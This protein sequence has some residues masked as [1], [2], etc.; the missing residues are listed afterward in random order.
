MP[1]N[2]VEGFRKRTNPDKLRFYNIGQGSA[3]ECMYHLILSHLGYADTLALQADA[4]EVSRLLQA[5]ING[6]ER[7]DS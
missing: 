7:N 6:L 2:I 1:A 3:D 4:E 5:Y